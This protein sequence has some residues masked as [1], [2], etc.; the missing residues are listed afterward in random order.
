MHAAKKI[1]GEAVTFAIHTLKGNTPRGHDHR[2]R[3][4]EL[5]DTCISNTG[6]LETWGGPIPL[7]TNPKW[8]DIVAANIHDKGAMMFEDSL[9]TCRINTMMNV[10]LLCQAVSAVTGWNFSWEEGMKVGL[11]I[12]NILRAFNTRHGIIGLDAD[13]P[14]PRYG[15]APDSGPGKGESLQ[16]NWDEMLN[17]YYTG[18]GWDSFG[19]PLPETLKKYGIEYITKDLWPL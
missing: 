8:P 5:F 14:S 10:D 6:T 1:G 9:V 18:M 16:D 4:T 7:G 19:K 2:N 3:T 15:S 13:R 11:R 12:V 17:T